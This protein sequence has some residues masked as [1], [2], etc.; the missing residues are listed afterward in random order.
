MPR[1]IYE[2]LTGKK[3]GTMLI[4]GKAGKDKHGAILWKAICDCGSQREVRGSSLKKGHTT[5]CGCEQ[6]R[7]NLH[8]LVGKPSRARK[9][10]GKSAFNM[11]VRRY[12]Q[13]AKEKGLPYEL[14]EEEIKKLLDGDCYYCG[15]KPAQIMKAPTTYGEYVY[16][17]IDR[18]KNEYGYVSWNV[19]SCCKWCNQAKNALSEDEFFD[20]IE[21]IY[22]HSLRRD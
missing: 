16:N 1:G 12:K 13:R 20:L 14:S 7:I 17:G 5:S 21:K 9:E 18:R 10:Y 6:K 19:V 22:D 15:A 3:F 4:L 2:D 8:H 11:L